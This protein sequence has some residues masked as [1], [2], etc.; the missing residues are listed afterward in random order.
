M[1]GLVAAIW[2]TLML[3]GLVH[4]GEQPGNVYTV[5]VVPQFEA[6]RLQ[7]IWQPLLERL[8]KRTG[9]S[10]RMQA[11]GSIREFERDLLRGRFDFAYM[12]P[13]QLIMA[14]RAKGYLPLVRDH[15]RELCGVLV[16]RKDSTID[17][18]RD[19][20]GKPVAFPSPNAL[21]A[22]LQMRQELHDRFGITTH[23]KY[24]QSH[25]RVYL[26]VL[27]GETLAGGGVLD[28]LEAQK[29]IYRNALRVIY[30]TA[31]VEPHPLAAL[32]TVPVEVRQKVQRAL[33]HMGNAQDGKRL[34]ARIPMRQIGPA[35]LE[36]YEPLRLKGLERFALSPD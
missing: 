23:P 8:G 30:T 6:G 29:P 2:A 21:G 28:T 5:G 16:V 13:Y 35:T 19:L 20:Q 17:D 26:N 12:N 14:N 18:P 10:F 9:Y 33:L 7:H 32:P 4:A 31:K 22:S 3:V 27:L 11:S 15:G 36:D 34:L 24:V 25:D 1:K